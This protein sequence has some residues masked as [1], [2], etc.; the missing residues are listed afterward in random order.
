MKVSPWVLRLRHYLVADTPP[1][2]RGERWRSALAA[3]AGM[4]LLQGILALIPLG[5]EVSHLLAPLGATSIILFALP[6]SPLG[7]PWPMAAGLL[8]CALTGWLCGTWIHSEMLAIASAV[9]I[10][11]WLMAF[12]RCIHPPGGAMAIV[13]VFGAAHPELLLTVALNVLTMLLVVLTINNLLP[14]RRYPVG[15]LPPAPSALPPPRRSA[16]AHDDLRH[17]LGTIDTYLDISEEDLVEVYEQA[18]AHALQR[19]ERRLCLE[20]MTPDPL[21]IEYGD[22]LNDA[23]ALLRRHRLKAL[24]VIDRSR[25][26]IGL[27]TLDDFLQHIAPDPGHSIAANIQR[28][29]QRSGKSHSERPEVVGQIMQKDVIVAH[30]TDSIVH[31][32]ALLSAR[33]HP[34]L[35]PV[36][37]AAGR[38]AGALSQTDVLSALYHQR[39]TDLAASG[40]NHGAPHSARA[41]SQE[42]KTRV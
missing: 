30:T 7:Q 3:L 27:L 20:I 35:I 15:L 34:A 37:D 8:L 42:E 33:T 41:A 18:I 22:S 9:A 12:L 6:H 40:I 10:S 39:V 11:V 4:L 19:H 17:A 13:C 16:I 23:W 26:L 31:I 24:P 14:G 21:C 28:L 25:R 2:S 36:L 1:L 5:S 32:A 29:L 38:V